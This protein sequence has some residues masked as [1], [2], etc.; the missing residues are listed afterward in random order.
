MS[1]P[2]MW[3]D[4]RTADSD[5]AAEFYRQMFRWD[6]ADAGVGGYQSWIGTGPQSWAGIVTAA[7]GT[8]G[9]WLPFVVVDD[10]DQ[11]TKQAVSLGATV[12]S[13]ASDGPAGT[14]VTIADP[15]G[16]KLALFKPFPA[17]K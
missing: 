13:E 3:F 16:A 11:A 7:P 17:A 5:A 2:F 1:V 10:L 8:T 6:I 9:E 12:T 15:G 4:L 14:S